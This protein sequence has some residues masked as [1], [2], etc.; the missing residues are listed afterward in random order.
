[1]VRVLF[2]L[3]VLVASFMTAFTG[4]SDTH[5]PAGPFTGDDTLPPA[6][7]TDVVLTVSPE[8]G[9]VCLE[10]TAPH[11]DSLTERVAG[12]EIRVVYTNG[13]DPE[14]FWSTAA[15][16]SDPPVP[17]EPRTRE[18]Y[19]IGDPLRTRDLWV[20]LRSVDEEGNRSSP[21]ELATIHVPGY[22]F[23]ARC[24]D[25]YTQL[26]V[27]GLVVTLS[28][29]EAYR[30]TTD[31]SGRFIHDGELDGGVTHIEILMGR[32]PTV[33]HP[34]N[35]S[36]ALEGDSAH[37]FFMIPVEA[38]DAPW[39]PNLLALFKRIAVISPHAGELTGESSAGPQI[40]AKWHHR[41]VPCYIPPFVNGQEV[42]YE[43]QAKLAATRWMER[44][45]EPLFVF[46]ESVPDTGIIVAYKPRSDMG[47]GIG[48]TKHTRGEDGHPMRDAIW[49]V[50][51]ASDTFV[52]YKIFLHEFGH[53]IP[54][55][56]V[57][58][59]AFLMFMGQP[60]PD[61]ISDDETRVVQLHESLPTRIDMS[62]YDETSPS[63]DLSRD[64]RW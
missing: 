51:E 33:Y 16:V 15:K 41:P 64:D 13:Y 3:G 22:T 23:A 62:I 19:T 47:G 57:D 12:Y 30:Y 28:T 56:H 21:S 26:P 32:S 49:V 27:E 4:C 43:A 9:E 10:W 63:G 11:D 14:D 38:V 25:V 6:P 24:V 8:A 42:D 31:A 55:G 46:V 52:L 61:D 50:D 35:Q 58:D 45:G 40:L 7:V 54:L 29:G 59:Q 34:L 37:T 39:V 18:R 53:T 60:I 36:F 20:G 48:V 17:A 44:T 5:S 1:M 2:A